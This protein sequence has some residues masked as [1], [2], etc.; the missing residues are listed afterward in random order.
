MPI[1]LKVVHENSLPS[2][3]EFTVRSPPIY[4]YIR[5]FTSEEGYLGAE[6]NP[7]LTF[8]Q[9]DIID[10]NI[11]YVQTLPGQLQDL[12]SLD[13]TN[14]IRAVSGIDIAVDIVPKL[15]PL[16]VQNFT[17]IE[18]NS[19][20]LEEEFL[21]ISSRHFA[22]LNCDFVLID[23]PKHG[24]IAKSRFPGVALTK[25]TRKQVSVFKM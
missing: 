13:V 4:G 3:I 18:G 16:D 9:Q 20:V 15:I 10:G 11:Q 1:L 14:G 22:G 17:V 7:V 21:N 25:F 23:P 19:K 24:R 8:T 2:E 12:V 5:K 6:E